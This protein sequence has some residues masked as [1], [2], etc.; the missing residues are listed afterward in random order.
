MKTAPRF[1][2]T[3]RG[4]RG[5]V[6]VSGM[7]F[8]QYGGNT[9]CV[10]VVVNRRR[11]I[12]DAGSGVVPLGGEMTEEG[13]RSIDL[14]LSHA[15]YDHVIGLPFFEPLMHPDVDLRLWYAGCDG[16]EDGPE[17]LEQLLRRPFLPFSPRDIRCRL[18][19]IALPKDGRT[20]LEEDIIIRTLPLNHP[21]RATAMRIEAQGC[22]LVYAPDFEAD[23]G[24]GDAALVEFMR[25]ATLA[26]LD[27]TYLP[28]EYPAR[29]GFGH[30]H[31]QHCCALADRADVVRWIP[32][33]HHYTRT[34]VEMGHLA[35]S[36]ADTTPKAQLMREGGSVD[37]LELADLSRQDC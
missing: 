18:H 36:L 16:A 2:A 1:N 6:P 31:W 30:S 13:A 21:G 22:S 37:I 27:A 20:E 26:F 11:L 4:A 12:L 25:G 7:G 24:S 17:L 28:H 29:K 23:G 35:R 19:H 5:S 10:E 8:S 32:F 33:H 34:D 9:P 15:H 3:I 14:F